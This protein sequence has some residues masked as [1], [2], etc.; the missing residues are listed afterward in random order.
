MFTK[1][2]DKIIF[3]SYLKNTT[4]EYSTWGYPTK[5]YYKMMQKMICYLR[6]KISFL[7]SFLPL[8]VSTQMRFLFI[9]KWAESKTRQKIIKKTHVNCF[10]GV[11]NKIV[12]IFVCLSFVFGQFLPAASVAVL[13]EN[14]F[15]DFIFSNLCV[16][17]RLELI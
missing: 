15:F 2:S 11:L 4:K 14:L 17:Q 13:F 7:F 6:D 16:S 10:F 5:K 12:C 8:K 1:E 3:K 9:W